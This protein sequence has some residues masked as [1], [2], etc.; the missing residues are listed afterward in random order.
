VNAAASFRASAVVP[1]LMEEP[2]LNLSANAALTSLRDKWRRMVRKRRSL[3]ELAVCPPSELRR[4]A[5][6][7]GVS[8]SDLRIIA[9]AHPGPS[10]LLP[11]RLELLGLDPGYVRS[12]QTAI[13]RDME[14]TC[15]MCPAWK[16]CARDLAKGDVQAGMD[17]YCLCSP[18]I[19]AL[20]VDETG[21]PPAMTCEPWL[22]RRRSTSWPMFHR[23]ERRAVRMQEMMTRLHVDPGK[24]ARLRR[25]DAYA[26]ARASCLSCRMSEKCLRW[27]G[28]PAEADKRPEFCPNLTLFEACQRD[29][30]AS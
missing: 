3:V 1:H 10:E 14:R 9:A 13:Y 22:P 30:A 16:R 21:L 24:L 2:M 7:V 20:A 8:V 28:D 5:Q 18:T 25:G 29:R 6:D 19:D 27:L 4:I 23:V 26:E 11:L 12:A 15:A 17:S